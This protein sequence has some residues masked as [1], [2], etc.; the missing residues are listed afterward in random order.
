M[1]RL[2][3]DPSISFEEYLHYAR[4]FLA[5]S[6]S[7][8]STDA[9][10]AKAPFLRLPLSRRKTE[11]N[12]VVGVNPTDERLSNQLHGAPQMEHHKDVKHPDGDEDS[13]V[14]DN[15]S[16]AVDVIHSV[17]ITDEEWTLAARAARTATWSGVFYLIT[18]DIMGPFS[19]P[20]AFSQ[21]GYGPGT[22]LYTVFGIV[23]G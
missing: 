22:A 20:W 12:V 5:S 8:E 17:V 11:E 13:E 1:K 23:A 15:R 18:T 7:R 4:E 9:P 19:V 6:R 3:H 10:Q 14:L 2:T 21:M 16:P